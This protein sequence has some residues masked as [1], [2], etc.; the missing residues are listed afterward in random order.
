MQP[1]YRGRR[2]AAFKN[3]VEVWTVRRWPIAV[4]RLRQFSAIL[5]TAISESRRSDFGS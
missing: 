5:M 4:V 3:R 2:V 1:E